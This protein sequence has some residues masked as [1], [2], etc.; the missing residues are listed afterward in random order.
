[1]KQFIFYTIVVFSIAIT[2]Q[3]VIVTQSA[4]DFKTL[5]INCPF[6]GCSLVV[7][8][9]FYGRRSTSICP[10]SGACS[11]TNCSSA[12]ARDIYLT[13]CD[14]QSCSMRVDPKIFG[15]PCPT[16]SK[17]LEAS[18]ECVPSNMI[19]LVFHLFKVFFL[20]YSVMH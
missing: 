19:I 15:S 2:A 12:N 1:M 11:I 5:T 3:S 13:Q 17:Y 9:V 7:K 18:Y 16:V 10:C 14:N 4:C 8:E 20:N 6:V